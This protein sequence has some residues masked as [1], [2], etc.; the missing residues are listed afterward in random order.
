MEEKLKMI[1]DKKK[2]KPLFNVQFA[3][4]QNKLWAIT[5]TDTI[6]FIQKK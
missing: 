1:I 5:R 6:K 2:I 3:G 4:V